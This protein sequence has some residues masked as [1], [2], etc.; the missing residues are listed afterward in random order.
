[1]LVDSSGKGGYHL[2]VLFNDPAPTEDIFSFAKTIA[3]T[4]E[5]NNLDEEPETFPKRLKIESLGSWFRLPGLHH[6]HQHYGRVWSGDDWLDDP[7]LDGHAAIDTILNVVPGPPPPSSNKNHIEP[8]KTKR[9]TT[10]KTKKA[11]TRKQRYKSKGKATICIDLDGVLA[12]RTYTKGIANIGEPIDGAV[13]F[14]HDLA[15]FAD[16]IIL[17]SRFSGLKD[18]QAIKR[19][20]KKI[21]KWLEKHNFSYTQVWTQSAKPPAQAYIDDHGVYCCPAKEGITAFESAHRATQALCK[22]DKK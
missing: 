6:T 21:V 15:E 3:S 1:L 16:I 8:R 20:E 9:S 4:W 13:D 11:T 18:A 14:S 19:T 22:I 5:R 10:T 7:W 12:D 2:W 17:T